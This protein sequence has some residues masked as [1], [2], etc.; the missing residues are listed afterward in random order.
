MQGQVFV[1]TP[2]HH[3]WSHL[4]SRARGRR[5]SLQEGR[6]F[7]CR[8]C[9]CVA[10]SGAW[11]EPHLGPQPEPKLWGQEHAPRRALAGATG[12]G[13][14]A[15]AGITG[16]R[17][18]SRP[19]Q[20]SPT[21]SNF[22][23]LLPLPGRAPSLPLAVALS[24]CPGAAAHHWLPPEGWAHPLTAPSHCPQRSRLALSSGSS[25][26]LSLSSPREGSCLT[27]SLPGAQ[28]PPPL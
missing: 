24:T 16:P 27:A 1:C 9:V 17:N 21:Q 28:S 5:P 22:L 2:P 7:H 25:V 14:S 12:S 11:E 23:L 8:Q 19:L 26:L 18:R 20:P 6:C 3:P 10:G 15:Q 13:P 4:S